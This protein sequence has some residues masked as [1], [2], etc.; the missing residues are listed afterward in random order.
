MSPESAIVI[1]VTTFGCDDPDT[2]EAVIADLLGEA[3]EH[4]GT[5]VERDPPLVAPDVEVG[6]PGAVLGHGR[7]EPIL[8][9]RTLLDPDHLGTE[10]T[11][12]CRAERASDEPAE[13]EDADAI[14]HSH[15]RH[16]SRRHATGGARMGGRDTP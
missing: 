1:G 15:G 5:G 9:T 12:E 13:V 4:G 11:Q 3:H 8:T 7:Q 6:R 2:P 14:E 10:V 16:R